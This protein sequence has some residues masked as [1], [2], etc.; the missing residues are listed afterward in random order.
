MTATRSVSALR[1]ALLWHLDP[2]RAAT[3]TCPERGRFQVIF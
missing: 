1:T 2:H 3:Q